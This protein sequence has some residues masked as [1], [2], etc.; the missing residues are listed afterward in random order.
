MS[1]MARPLGFLQERILYG[2]AG[3][4]SDQRRLGKSDIAGTLGNTNQ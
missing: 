3:D 1:V 4:I 2:A